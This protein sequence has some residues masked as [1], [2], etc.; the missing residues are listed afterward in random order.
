MPRPSGDR[1]QGHNCLIRPTHGVSYPAAESKSALNH[2]L[3]IL[4]R[5]VHPCK[6]FSNLR[7]AVFTFHVI[8]KSETILKCKRIRNDSLPH[9]HSCE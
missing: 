2:L 6:T 3:K 4:E 7:F 8:K 5:I 9:K 1:V